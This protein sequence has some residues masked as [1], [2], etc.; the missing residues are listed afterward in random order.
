MGGDDISLQIL[1]CEFPATK[2]ITISG[3]GRSG[4]VEFLAVARLYGAQCTL[5]KPCEGRELLA[6]VREVLQS[7]SKPHDLG[8]DA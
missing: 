1:R 4:L 8:R 5:H 6:A 2:I 3:G 7:A